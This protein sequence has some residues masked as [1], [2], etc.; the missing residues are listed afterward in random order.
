MSLFIRTL[1]LTLALAA[2]VAFPTWIGAKVESGTELLESFSRLQRAAEGDIEALESL[3]SPSLDT[4]DWSA[5]RFDGQWVPLV[6]GHS[7]VRKGD[8]DLAGI[9]RAT[10]LPIDAHLSRQG[11]R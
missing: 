4:A 7:Q 5:D 3:T 6:Q 2:L 9:L 1:P 10:E 11:Q 8:A